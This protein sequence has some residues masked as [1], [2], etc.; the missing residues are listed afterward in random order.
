MRKT[1]PDSGGT[2]SETHAE[3]AKSDEKGVRFSVES[4]AFVL[5]EIVVIPAGGVSCNGTVVLQECLT[6]DL[7]IFEQV[8]ILG[9]VIG[10]LLCM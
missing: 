2:K 4:Y 9:N 5:R 7:G 3:A 8:D 6:L 1:I 10:D